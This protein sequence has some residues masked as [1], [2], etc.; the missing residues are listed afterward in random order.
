MNTFDAKELLVYGADI[1]VQD[2]QDGFTAA[3]IAAQA[4]NV[5]LLEVARMAELGVPKQR[6]SNIFMKPVVLYSGWEKQ[7]VKENR[8]D[9]KG[10]WKD[11]YWNERVLN[12]YERKLRQN[13]GH[14]RNA[15]GNSGTW[16]ELKGK[17]TDFWRKSMDQYSKITMGKMG[18]KRCVFFFNR[19]SDCK[20]SKCKTRWVLKIWYSNCIPFLSFYFEY[21][22][23]GKSGIMFFMFEF[24]LQKAQLFKIFLDFISIFLHVP[25]SCFVQWNRFGASVWVC[26]HLTHRSAANL[27][28]DDAK[29]VHSCHTVSQS[30][31]TTEARLAFPQDF[32]TWDHSK[33]FR[34]SACWWPFLD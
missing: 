2:V 18:K 6:F 22:K 15:K 29:C 5:E 30:S 23:N 19:Y 20:N 34:F 31:S 25:I 7:E 32:L 12:K 13:G 11:I 14:Q 8:E 10:L 17:D 1:H 24:N 26:S 33:W 16:K 21:S 9:M 28:W 4:G 27:N 3:G